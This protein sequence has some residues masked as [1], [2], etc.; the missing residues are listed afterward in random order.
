MRSNC[1]RSK[2]RPGGS[3]WNFCGHREDAG[4]LRCRRGSDARLARARHLHQFEPHELRE[5]QA[6][7]RSRRGAE[8]TDG[9]LHFRLCRGWRPH[10]LCREFSGSRETGRNLCRQDLPRRETR[11][12]ADR[13]ADAARSDDQPEDGAST[14]PGDPAIVAAARHRADRM[15][16]AAARSSCSIAKGC[17]RPSTTAAVISFPRS[18]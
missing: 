13:A 1:R 7:H 9:I 16:Q 2:R 6:N 15:R 10:F 17:A 14:G 11:R 8:N 12:P 5:P 3:A 18:K 4:R